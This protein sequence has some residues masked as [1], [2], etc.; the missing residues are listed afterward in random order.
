MIFLRSLKT[1]QNEKNFEVGKI[2]FSFLIPL[3]ETILLF[4]K[5]D[6]LTASGMAKFIWAKMSNFIP[7]SLRLS[8][9]E[10]SLV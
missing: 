5:S 3:F 9:I 1:T 4:P 7:L 2:F 6:P 8:G 10:F